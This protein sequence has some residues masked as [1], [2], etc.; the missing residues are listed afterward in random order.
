[1]WRL[2]CDLSGFD[3]VERITEMRV[4]IFWVQVRFVDCTSV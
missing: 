3:S 4:D 1:M 2:R